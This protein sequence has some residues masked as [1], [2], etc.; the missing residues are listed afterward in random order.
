MKKLSIITI[1]YNDE[2][3]LKDTF[4]SVFNQAYKDFEYLVIDGKSNDGSKKLLETHA[5]Q[6]DYWVSE[7]DK[8]V[9]NAMNKGIKQAKGEYLL[10]LNSGDTLYEN[11]TLEEIIPQLDSKND[12]YY[13]DVK[14]KKEN[15]L[16]KRTYPEKLDFSFFYSNSL[17]HQSSFIKRELFERF[18]Y[19][20]ENYKIASDWEFFAYAICKE[21][22][23]YKHLNQVV[24]LYDFSGMS[25]QKENANIH[26]EERLQSIEKYFP[27]FADDYKDISKL[28]A[29]RTQQLFHIQNH[30]WAWKIL[31]G[32]MNL[33]LLFLP[34]LKK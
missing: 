3:G 11:T 18:F 24:C 26:L 20:N 10:F 9:Y 27:A 33:I 7:P 17:C 1:N 5:H 14:R 12:I 4:E 25:S 19:Y 2:K 21:N 28:K 29:K 6:I 22:A 8:G 23:P 13:G 15:R 32:F 34:K 31:K 16:S 30:K